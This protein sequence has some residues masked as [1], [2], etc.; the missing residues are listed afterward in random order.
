MNN[1]FVKTNAPIPNDKLLLY[2]KVLSEISQFVNLT[3]KGQ[4]HISIY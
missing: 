2:N 3:L 1:V 4:N